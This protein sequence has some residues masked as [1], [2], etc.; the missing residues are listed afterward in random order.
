[1]TIASGK[2][3]NMRRPLPDDADEVPGFNEAAI[4]YKTLIGKFR[5]DIERAFATT[6][7]E[8]EMMPQIQPLIEQYE[9][10]IREQYH[11][12]LQAALDYVNAE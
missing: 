4:E 6:S 11:A 10:L 3:V 9:P 7:A 12:M 1:M 5:L 8:N 2:P